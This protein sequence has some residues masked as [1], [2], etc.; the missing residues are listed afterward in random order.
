MNKFKE[1]ED[2]Y[3]KAIRYKPQ[4][5]KFDVEMLV[6]LGIIYIKNK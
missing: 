3:I 4:E 1:A 2:R 6:K 5:V